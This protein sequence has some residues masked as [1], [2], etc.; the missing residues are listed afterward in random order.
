MIA[1]ATT[2]QEI[3]A[4]EKLTQSRNQYLKNLFSGNQVH[5]LQS[6]WSFW[7][8]EREQPQKEAKKES[9]Q[10]KLK[11]IGTV[12]SLESFFGMYVYLKRP[13]EIER[14]VDLHFFRGGEIPMW[15]VSLL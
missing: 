10:E 14:K 7:L 5:H 13:S 1:T 2:K 12:N 3:E 11:N 4:E 9:Y 6:D 8:F 15:E